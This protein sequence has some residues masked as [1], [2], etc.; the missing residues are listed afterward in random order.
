[1]GKMGMLHAAIL[2]SI[3]NV[4][5]T[6]VVDTEK[7]L[8]DFIEK[9]ASAIKG[10]NNYLKM[11]D[12]S[13]L[14]LV[15]ITTPVHSH[16]EIA[17]EC[18]KRNLHFFVEKPLGRTA[19]ECETLCK[20]IKEH[21]VVN[22]VGFYLRYSDTFRK[23]KKLLDEGILGKIKEVNSSVFQ[24]LE[25]HKGS[26]W[27]FKKKLSGGGILIDLGIH[28]IDLLLWFFGK[29][30]TVQGL[31]ES[32]NLQNIEDYVSAKLTFE[33]NLS[34]SLIASWNEKNYRLQET[35]IEIEGTFGKMKVNEDFLKID[36][37]KSQN[38][39]KNN[40]IFYRQTLYKGIE[41]DIG[42]PEYTKEDV[43]F[44]NSIMN[45]QQSN[46]NVI[47][48]SMVQSVIDSIYKSSKT[49]KPE[50]VRFFE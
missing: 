41:V 19:H 50:G 7:F 26:S 44:I 37:K 46:L 6:A 4:R 11:L 45:K 23:A 35:T 13:D 42:G 20:I 18:A 9:N 27:R 30:K 36:F 1:M 5:V 43:D 29:I 38:T 49:K 21:Q 3:D 39:E 12:Q 47:H 48:S 8:I 28:L 31:T 40:M 14:D 32:K 15:Y 22:M 25:F 17:S 24:T 2:N 10:Y 34:C 33:N 16:I